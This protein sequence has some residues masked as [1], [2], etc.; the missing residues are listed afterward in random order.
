MQT[1]AFARNSSVAVPLAGVVARL[2]LHQSWTWT[3][4]LKL[5]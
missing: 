2:S 5:L 3:L 4:I 1:N